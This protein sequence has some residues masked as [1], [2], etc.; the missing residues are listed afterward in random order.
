M[1]IQRRKKR[2]SRRYTW[3]EMQTSSHGWSTHEYTQGPASVQ[4][5]DREHARCKGPVSASSPAD[6]FTR[7][8]TPR[9]LLASSTR[10]FRALSGQGLPRRLTEAWTDS[11][12]VCICIYICMYILSRQIK[13]K[14][15]YVYIYIYIHAYTYITCLSNACFENSRVRARSAS[16]SRSKTDREMNE[17][18]RRRERERESEQA[19][20][21]GERE[22]TRDTDRGIETFWYGASGGLQ[23]TFK[24]TTVTTGTAM[25]R[26][27][28]RIVTRLK[29]KEAPQK[30]NYDGTSYFS[31]IDTSKIG[32]SQQ[33][34][35]K[36]N[37]F[38]CEARLAQSL[39][40]SGSQ[41]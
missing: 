39:T 5:Q 26:H 33:G 24:P 36:A 28:S 9:H 8:S 34:L 10:V 1:L 16:E 37:P 22:R 17:R 31:L 20:E 40:L 38:G 13:N 12:H 14:N 27:G 35:C 15:V 29:T 7:R 21:Q 30:I 25:G 2:E 11:R 6:K 19:S 41:F 3:E 32:N 4:S 23:T 18:E